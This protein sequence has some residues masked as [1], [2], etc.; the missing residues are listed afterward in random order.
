[1]PTHSKTIWFFSILCIKTSLICYV[2][3]LVLMPLYFQCGKL[4]KMGSSLKFSML[5]SLWVI[6][7]F[8]V[9]FFVIAN[10]ATLAICISHPAKSRYRCRND[11]YILSHGIFHISSRIVPESHASAWDSKYRPD[12][13]E[14]RYGVEGRYVT[15][16]HDTTGWYEKCHVIMYL[17]HHFLES[18]LWHQYFTIVVYVK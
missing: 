14:G 11:M 7:R 15:R 6:A 4:S 1:M 16:G 2:T 18:T 12:R 13:R 9:F 8:Y 10:I 3:N 17:Y 5:Y